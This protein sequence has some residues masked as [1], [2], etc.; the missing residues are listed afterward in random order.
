MGEAG[1]TGDVVGGR[2]EIPEHADELSAT[3]KSDTE[4]PARERDEET[5][6]NITVVSG[7]QMNFEMWVTNG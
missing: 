5:Q 2:A 4:G 1:S 7:S 3:I 6:A